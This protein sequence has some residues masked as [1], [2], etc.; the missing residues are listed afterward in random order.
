MKFSWQ[1][2][3]W[4]QGIF[5]VVTAAWPFVHLPSFLFVTGPKTD[6]WLLYTVAGLLLAIGSV[7]LLAAY[8]HAVTRE[9]QVLAITAALVLIGIDLVY[10]TTN[11]ISDIYRL[12]ALAEAALIAGWLLS[13]PVQK[14]RRQTERS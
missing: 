12:D 14:S 7:L 9:L 3:A 1:L 8:R 5:Y 10:S 13:G 11:T 6:I 2:M 4:L